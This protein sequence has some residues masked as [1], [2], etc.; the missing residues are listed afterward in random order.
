MGGGSRLLPPSIAAALAAAG[1]RVTFARFMG[2]ALTDAEWGYYARTDRLLGRHGHFTTAPHRVPAFN[3]AISAM[4][5]EL[6]DIL[7]RSSRTERVTVV[8]VGG[9]EGDLAAGILGRWQ[10]ARPDLRGRTDY[11][12]V[13]L[14]EGL[15]RAQRERLAG[16]RRQGWQVRWAPDLG[17]CGPVTGI[18]VSNELV[19]A[20]PVHLVNVSGEHLRE[21]WVRL[22]RVPADLADHVHAVGAT[23]CEEWGDP[24]L[25]ALDELQRV[26]GTVEPALLRP[27]SRDGFIELRPA[28][29]GFLEQA[30]RVLVDGAVLT[31]DYG[32]WLPGTEPAEPEAP[33]HVP[34]GPGGPALHGR[35][36]RTYFHHQRGSDPLSLVGRQDLT[37]DVDFRALHRHGL[38]LGFSTATYCL[39]S[40]LLAANGAAEGLEKLRPAVSLSLDADIEA[41]ALEALLDGRGLGGLFKAMLQ[42]K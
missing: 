3:Q 4:L 21:S 30:A 34:L 26:F 6:V 8:E 2:L 22:D 25:D 1:G 10:A 38:G 37:A 41:S 13:E 28:A 16:A 39:L 27:L 35:T 33:A 23:A 29:R 40:E 11:L 19:D 32:D 12:L 31:M 36:L 7:L 18:L 5:A 9:G 24:S 15:R 17:G 14:G 42:V 20:L